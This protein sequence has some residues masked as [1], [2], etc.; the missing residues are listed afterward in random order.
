MGALA[1][2]PLVESLVS[3]SM[4]VEDTG[5]GGWGG[6]LLEASAYSYEDCAYSK[7][8]DTTVKKVATPGGKVPSI[9]QFTVHNQKKQKANLYDIYI[10]VEIANEVSNKTLHAAAR[11][12]QW[13]RRS[14]TNREIVGSIPMLGVFFAC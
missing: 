5:G 3:S 4:E 13:I 14:T 8:E 10:K 1:L 6:G 9:I 7:N 11:L 12:A 2:T